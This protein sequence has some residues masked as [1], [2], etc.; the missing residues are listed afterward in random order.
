MVGH[1]PLI[2]D[3]LVSGQPGLVLVVQKLPSASVPAVTNG[4]DQAVAQ[5]RPALAGV[6]IDTSLF[7]PATYIDTAFHNL[8]TALIASAI[9]IAL[10]LLALLLT[11]GWPR[12]RW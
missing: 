3:G 10:A 1:Q 11:C 6:Q 8:G 5:L 7:R 2:G 4:M 9:L 12:S